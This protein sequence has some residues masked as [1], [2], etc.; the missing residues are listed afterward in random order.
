MFNG[1]FP[2]AVFPGDSLLYWDGGPSDRINKTPLVNTGALNS[3]LIHRANAKIFDVGRKIDCGSQIAGTGDITLFAW[4]NANS[5]GQGSIGRVVDNGKFIVNVTSTNFLLSV[6]S[7][8]ATA[9][10]SATSS[11]S[12]AVETF[13]AVTR[14]SA[15]VVNIYK[16]GVLSGTA[17]QASG[18]TANGT[19]NLIIGNNNAATS[20]FDGTISHV[21]IF[22]KILSVTQ[23]GQIYNI[24][25]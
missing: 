15:G 8:G 22:S 7:D 16:N 21:R 18:T 17:N 2:S 1:I 4:F 12:T 23:I 20:S 13:V 24:E 6:S 11:I 5:Y 19:T 25:K 9:A 10:V 14:T 3:S